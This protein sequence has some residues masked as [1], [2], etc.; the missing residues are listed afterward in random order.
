MKNKL[1][2]YVLAIK[3]DVQS[4]D[5]I[6]ITRGNSKEEALYSYA[7]DY[8]AKHI[9]FLENIEDRAINGSFWEIFLTKIFELNMPEGYTTNL[10][11]DEFENK[12]KELIKIY[13]GEHD[14][15]VETLFNFYKDESKTVKDLDDEL[16]TLIAWK[17][18][19]KDREFYI[20][21]EINI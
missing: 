9:C 11:D 1:K 5:D 14:Q 18:I 2:L 4:E 19:S 15:Y 6:F 20:I 16:L 10:T 7:K 21:K 13:L 8:W 3:D 17:S 12:F